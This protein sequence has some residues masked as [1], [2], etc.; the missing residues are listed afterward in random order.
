MEWNEPTSHIQG[1]LC[2]S[3]ECFLGI[4]QKLVEVQS[5]VIVQK[6]RN[7]IGFYLIPG[8]SKSDQYFSRNRPDS[9]CGQFHNLILDA[10]DHILCLRRQYQKIALES[11]IIKIDWHMIRHYKAYLLY[12]MFSLHTYHLDWFLAVNKIAL[13]Y[14]DIKQELFLYQVKYTCN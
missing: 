3:D 11:S 4:S 2:N 12:Y 8:L 14:N 9:K 10:M 7:S 13:D 5:S 1:D 6:K